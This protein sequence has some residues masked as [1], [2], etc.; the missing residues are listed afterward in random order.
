MSFRSDN[1]N[2]AI[3]R[4]NYRAVAR[5]VSEEEGNKQTLKDLCLLSNIGSFPQCH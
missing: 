5:Q 3:L 4:Q 1:E 2:E